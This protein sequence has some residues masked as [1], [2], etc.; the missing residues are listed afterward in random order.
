V[1]EDITR[2]SS[3]ELQKESGIRVAKNAI[4]R[5][6]QQKKGLYRSDGEKLFSD[7]EHEEMM[8]RFLGELRSA[9]ERQ[10]ERAEEDYQAYTEEE[11]SYSYQDPTATLSADERSRL[12]SSA[13]FVREDVDE[14]SLDQLENRLRALVVGD[15]KVAKVLHARYAARRLTQLD[16]AAA[17]GQL[18]QDDMRALGAIDKL[19]S[20]LEEQIADKGVRERRD[21]AAARAARAKAVAWHLKGMLSEADGTDQRAREAFSRQFAADF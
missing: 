8:G 1:S 11:C 13:V 15:Q 12:T 9:I 3:A 19:V 21:K 20:Q 4:R 6:E 10:I 14:M 5:F 18:G 7:V 17:G 2:E 16:D